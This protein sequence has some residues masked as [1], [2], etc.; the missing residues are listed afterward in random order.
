MGKTLQKKAFEPERVA[1]YEAEGWRAYYDRKWLR[2]IG[3][4][5]RLCQEQFNIP[6]P[7]SVVAA[8]YVGRAAKA[9]VPLDHDEALVLKYYEK[10]YRLARRYSGFSFDPAR[11]ARLEL[12]YNDIHRRLVGQADK[13]E[14]IQAMIELHSELF[15]LTPEQARESAELRVLANNTVDLISN[16]ISTDIPGDWVKIRNYLKS[17]YTS[18]SREAGKTPLAWP[19]KRTI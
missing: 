3:L 13:S 8:Y 2:L 14:F 16:K 6:F 11:V 5:V 12:Q 1:Y 15:G 17:C 18:V 9:W 7:L 4:M 10:F 19:S